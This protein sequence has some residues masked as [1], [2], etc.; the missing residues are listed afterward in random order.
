[1]TKLTMPIYYYDPNGYKI[2]PINKKELYALAENGTITPET[3]LTDE[4][5]EFQAKNIPKLKFYA[6]EYHRAEELFNLE[7]IDFNHIILPNN[8]ETQQTITTTPTQNVA[9]PQYQQTTTRPIQENN[10]NRVENTH[11][12]TNI[13]NSNNPF[14]TNIITPQHTDY[15]YFRL[16]L[17]TY[18]PLATIILYGGLTFTIFIT[19]TCLLISLLLAL[20]ILISGIILTICSAL[21]F[22]FF[23]D[24]VQY[25]INTEEHLKEI[26][27]RLH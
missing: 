19:L 25:M 16:V 24:Y 23:A 20:V 18:Y 27:N 5:I 1:M 4:K 26:K 6:P 22:G 8:S 15:W 3:R 7:N 14:T 2:G 10:I 17:K 21:T 9:I 12:F 13:T 11:L